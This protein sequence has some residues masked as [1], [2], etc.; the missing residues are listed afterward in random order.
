[1]FSLYPT[2]PES[3][4]LKRPMIRNIRLCYFTDPKSFDRYPKI[5]NADPSPF[6]LFRYNL[7]IL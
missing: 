1:M 7:S 4:C 3:T 2:F 5:A 6:T